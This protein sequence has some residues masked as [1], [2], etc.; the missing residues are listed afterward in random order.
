MKKNICLIVVGLL[1]Q[2]VVSGQIK[3]GAHF[4]GGSF[5]ISR[6][7][8]EINPGNNDFKTTNFLFSPAYGYALKKN[9]IIGGDL[10]LQSGKNENNN[11]SQETKG[12]GAGFFIRKYQPLGKG[13]YLFGQGRFGVGQTNTKS[14]AGNFPSIES[15]S[16]QT[17]VGLTVNPG[18]SYAINNKLQLEL[19]LNELFYLQYSQGSTETENS[20]VE[21]SFNNFSIG[22]NIISSGGL[23]VG[24]R[25]LINN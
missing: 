21:S 14:I 7:E 12:F 17:N 19:G 6:S 25:I 11:N 22:S 23:V 13:F 18:V 15:N 20:P 1:I 24:L 5:G 10:I 2:L 3:E 16:K 8:N 4:L 9:L